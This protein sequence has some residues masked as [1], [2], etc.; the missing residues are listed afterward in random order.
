MMAKHLPRHTRAARCLAYAL[1][2][3][4]AR[5]GRD[6]GR[7]FELTLT[8]DERGALSVAALLS[9]QSDHL[10]D[11]VE[12]LKRVADPAIPPLVNF[13]DEAATWAEYADRD[14]LKACT[15]IAYGCVPRANQSALLDHVQGR[16]A[17]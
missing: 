6:L 2:T 4:S 8:P 3:G 11:L 16:Q 14:K 5:G 1:G 10:A 7:A 12:A 15:R 9:L 17:A 13:S